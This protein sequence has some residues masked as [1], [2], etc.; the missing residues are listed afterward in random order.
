MR[1]TCPICRNSTNWEDNQHRPFCSER[2]R[3]IDLGHWAADDYR[4]PAEEASEVPAASEP[5]EGEDTP[6]YRESA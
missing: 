1:V 5:G 4:I 3:M 2:C 6:G